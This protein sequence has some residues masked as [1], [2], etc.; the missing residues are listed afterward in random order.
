M[1]PGVEEDSDAAVAWLVAPCRRVRRH[2]YQESITGSGCP[3]NVRKH[4]R[5]RRSPHP[6]TNWTDCEY[7]W[8]PRPAAIAATYL[9]LPRI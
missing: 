2:P 4:G 6:D 5:T 9:L 3:A 8:A 7:R 1:G